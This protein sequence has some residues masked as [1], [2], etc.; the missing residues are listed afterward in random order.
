M[1]IEECLF[2]AQERIGLG[3]SF[4]ESELEREFLEANP[5]SAFFWCRTVSADCRIRDKKVSIEAEVELALPTQ[6]L[7][8]RLADGLR[9]TRQSSEGEYHDRA[10]IQRRLAAAGKLLKRFKGK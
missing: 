5:Q 1:G 7:T 10:K 6:G 3:C 2:G 4:S 8:G 9:L